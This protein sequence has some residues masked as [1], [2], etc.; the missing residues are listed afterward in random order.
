MGKKTP[1]KLEF[2]PRALQDM[3]DAASYIAREL[4]EPDAAQRL[5]DDIADAAE[6]AACFPYAYPS[7]TSPEP[8][9]HEYRKLIVRNYI[10]F[11]W[12]D[13]Q[14][15]RILIERVLYMR[16]DCGTLL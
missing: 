13:D 5:L 8:L 9:E 16:R 7:H 6:R 4:Y 11:Y 10:V 2:L 14:E 15:K 12:I 3:T 1:Y